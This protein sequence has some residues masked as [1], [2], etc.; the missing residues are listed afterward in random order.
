M[1]GAQYPLPAGSRPGAGIRTVRVI[2]HRSG[3]P[4]AVHLT[5][6]AGP[7]RQLPTPTPPAAGALQA[8]KD[9]PTGLAAAGQ[10][11][12]PGE[13]PAPLHHHAALCGDLGLGARRG[14][15]TSCGISAWWHALVS[16]E[17]AQEAK[18]GG[19]F[20]RAGARPAA[21]SH[22]GGEKDPAATRSAG[23]ATRRY[24]TPQAV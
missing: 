13:P 17:E 11:S 22:L 9:A 2:P 3:V 20:A 19:D 1:R 15:T 14:H 8:S 7:R 5:H 23:V 16:L 6:G 10:H 12:I 24:R 21:H 18:A 4:A